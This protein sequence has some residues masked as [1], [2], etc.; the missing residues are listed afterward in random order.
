MSSVF[1]GYSTQQKLEVAT[2]LLRLHVCHK[3]NNVHVDLVRAVY[4]LLF[5][6]LFIQRVCVVWWRALR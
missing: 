6:Y 3:S 5:Q 1:V 2:R 4:V